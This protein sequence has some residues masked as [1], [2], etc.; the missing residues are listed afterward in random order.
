MNQRQL[1]AFRATMRSGSITE[2]AAMMHISQPSVSRLIGDLERSV[3]FDLFL[4]SGRGLT[5]TIEAKAFYQGVE[6]MFAGIERLEDLARTIRTTS[7]GMISIGTIQS[8]AAIEVPKAVNTIYQRLP[9]I[10]FMIQSRNTPAIL[11]AIQTHQLDIGIVG[12][13]P[14]YD[15]VEV[16]FQT[17][18]P[19]V[20]LMPEDHELAGDMGPVDLEELVATDE[21]VTFGGAFPDTMMEIDSVLAHKMQQR[22]R[23]FATNMPV[24]GSLVR[25][26]GVLA[27]AD[28][29]SAEQAVLMGG[30]IFRPLTQEL[31][32]H[33]S[34]I[35]PGK[36]RLSRAALEFVEVLA[37]RI[38]HRV[39]VVKRY[40][41]VSH[42]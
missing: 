34:I 6:G 27:I 41:T 16:L 4:R 23:L 8:I 26:A 22:S 37:N 21:F 17:V 30:V 31:K 7:T 20:C 1:E 38:S 25:E 11:D 40:G 5:P 15:G 28:P 32:Y 29:F 35:T 3:G 39:E 2:A 13:Q 9:E 36:D 14:P 18:A 19:Y 12:R 42:P 24:A 33:V 10:N